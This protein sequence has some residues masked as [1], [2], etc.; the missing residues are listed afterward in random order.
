MMGM[1]KIQ[2]CALNERH[3]LVAHLSAQQSSVP[4]W[5]SSMTVT[6]AGPELPPH[7]PQKLQDAE[8]RRRCPILAKSQ[9]GFTLGSEV[10]SD[11]MISI[12]PANPRDQKCVAPEVH[13]MLWAPWPKPSD[14]GPSRRANFA[15]LGPPEASR[16]GG[17][18]AGFQPGSS[19]CPAPLGLRVER[20]RRG[21]GVL[22]F[23][24]RINAELK[25][26]SSRD[27]VVS[28]ILW[29]PFPTPGPCSSL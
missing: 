1:K 24:S 21:W 29:S 27:M 12:Q 16:L 9:L 26:G 14:S 10:P 20:A 13:Q 4:W 2:L 15:S 25:V 8:F 19:W 22:A 6:W 23:G 3:S 17:Q 28:S 5:V 18:Q 11:P 7:P